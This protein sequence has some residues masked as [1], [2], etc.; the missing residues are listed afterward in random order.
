MSNQRMHISRR[1]RAALL[2]ELIYVAVLP[3]VIYRLASP[4]MPAMYALLLA[5]IPPTARTLFGL[6]RHGRIN[7]L[8]VFSLLAI[9]IKI[10]SGLVLQDT[11]SILISSSLVTGA[12]GVIMLA[13]LLSSTPLILTLFMNVL[14]G[15]DPAQREQFI[16]RWPEDGSR[17]FFVVITAL[18]GGGLLIELVVRIILTF[19]L[20]IEQFLVIGL[21]VQY[22][23]LVVMVLVTLLFARIRRSRKRK[24]PEQL[25]QQPVQETS[26][27][28]V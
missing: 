10:I 27:T 12:Y 8:G 24:L 14:A 5:G 11:R 9:A 4:H 28:S 2:P 22:S 3:Y 18:W 17:S 15:N 19:T 26:Q 13:S 6:T 25:S 16:K 21:I 20:T 23:F 1:L 7:L